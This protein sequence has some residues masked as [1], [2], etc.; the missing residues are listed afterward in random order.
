MFSKILHFPTPILL[1]FLCLLSSSIYAQ[2]TADADVIKV[3]AIETAPNIWKFDVTVQHPDQDWKDYCDGWNVVLENGH[4]VLPDSSSIF[5]RTL[6]HPHI[7][8]QPFTRSQ[9]GLYIPPDNGFVRVQAHDLK[10]GFGGKE[11]LLKL[12]NTQSEQITVMR[13]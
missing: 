3:L 4:V 7:H 13:F 10:A 2:N 11:L 9:S 12:E 8:E 6:F 5:T 1:F